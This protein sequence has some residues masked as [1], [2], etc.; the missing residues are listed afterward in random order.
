M[1]EDK[2]SALGQNADDA[3]R[4][5]LE[6]EIDETLKASFPASDPPSWTLGTDHV[7]ESAEDVESDEKDAPPRH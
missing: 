7:V 3:E 6:D 5:A 1:T 4:E 2:D